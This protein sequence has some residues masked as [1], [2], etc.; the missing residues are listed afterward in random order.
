VQN[1]SVLDVEVT[2]APQVGY[3]ALKRW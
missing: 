2:F 3:S 1:I